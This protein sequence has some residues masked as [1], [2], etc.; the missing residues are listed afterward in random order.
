[1]L[2]AKCA[3]FGALLLAAG[4]CSRTSSDALAASRIQLT[5]CAVAGVEGDARCGT[6]EVWE[7]RAAR[8]G[9]RIRLNILVLQARGAS[10]AEDPVFY[11][12]GGP[13]GGAVAA[14]PWVAALLRQVNESRDLVFVDA[15]GTGGSNPL[16]CATP[17][18]DA[19]LQEHFEEFLADDFVRDCLRR[20][21]ADVR[22]YTNPFAMDDVDEIRAE[23]GYRRI[24]LFGSSGGT[25]QE[26]VYMRRHPSSVRSV[27][28]HGVHPMD[29]EL[30]LPFAKALEHGIAALAAACARDE[31]CHASH[32]DLAGDWER[33]KR[34]FDTGPVYADVEHRRT[35]RRERV[36]I[37]RGVYADGVRH[38][39][40]TM[41]DA[42]RLPAL[43]RAA[44]AGD[45]DGFA[46]RELALSIAYGR[47][48]AHGTFM[49]STC[50]EDVR[51]I[52]EDDIRRE[53]DGTFL[54]DYRVRRQ[55]AACR[56]WPRGEGV[57]D[58]FQEPVRVNA[59]V[60]VLSGDADVA[61]PAANGERVAK[62]LPNATHIVFPNQG[63]AFSNPACASRLIADFMVA[64]S[65]DRLDLSCVAGTRRPRFGR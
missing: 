30:P 34:Q 3:L 28:M 22:F 54:G 18:D 27:V 35:G 26:Q 44:A 8:S 6:Y 47:Q 45:F 25:R 40:Y 56:I 48:L 46:Q 42:W 38:L 15:R 10:R 41:E 12:D 32:P 23:L 2:N 20:Q 60:L 43:I 9:R 62:A 13:G 58:G 17:E 16:R 63:H 64:A 59:P 19:P 1:M 33:S 4:G 61:T 11:F 24:N 37:T 53:T 49:S 36:R 55:Q 14:A 5:G 57:D 52:D 31:P 65:A 50:A 39:L 29:G 7:N 21:H 51:F